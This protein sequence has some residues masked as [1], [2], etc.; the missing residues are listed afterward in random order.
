MIGTHVESGRGSPPPPGARRREMGKPTEQIKLYQKYVIT[1]QT[2]KG[3][4]IKKVKK[5]RS[6]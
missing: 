3:S 1:H 2:F 4:V 6:S 5:L